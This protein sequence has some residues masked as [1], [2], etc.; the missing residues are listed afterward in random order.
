[1][2]AMFIQML[3]YV[4]ALTGLV[5]EAI[6][7]LLDEQ[8]IKFRPNLIAMIVSIVLSAGIYI[9][10]MIM[11]AQVW[12]S[13]SIVMMIALMFMSWLGSQVGYDKITDIIS[14]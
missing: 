10:N 1:M 4:S 3:F 13:Q 8:N 11:T 9:G 12:T 6:K 14:K 7:R 5:T 2:D